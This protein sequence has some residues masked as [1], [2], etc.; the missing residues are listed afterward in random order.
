[1]SEPTEQQPSDDAAKLETAVAQAIDACDGDPVAAVR[2]LI[3]ANAALE[4]ELATLYAKSS[5]RY[6]RGRRVKLKMR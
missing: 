4:H 2:A 3:V 5:R 1:M 6:L